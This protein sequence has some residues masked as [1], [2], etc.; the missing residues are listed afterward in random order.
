MKVH[1]G[2]DI[3]VIDIV[4]QAIEVSGLKMLPDPVGKHFII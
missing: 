2:I 4:R 1:N 3:I